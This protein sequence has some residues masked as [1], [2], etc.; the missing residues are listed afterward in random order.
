MILHR[1]DS[2]FLVLDFLGVFVGAVGGGILAIRERRYKYDFIG[3][4]G[5]AFASALGGGITRDI[6]LQNGPPLAFLDIRYE[7]V[8][9]AGA[10]VALGFRSRMTSGAQRLMLIVDAAAIGFF[11]VS[12]STRALHAGLARL[13]ALLLGVVTAVG[14]GSIGDIMSGRTPRIFEG[15]QFYAIAAL[16]GSAAFLI[17]DAAGMPRTVSSAIGVLACFLL[18]LL[19][20]RFDWRT[21]PVSE[22]TSRDQ[23]KEL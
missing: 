20:R 7:I 5:L 2:L 6:I 9:F 21:R 12:G 3:V 23:G 19:S 16:F 1:L 8:A 13:P 17:S 14:G 10:F 11:A 18:R 15:G 22:I 4:I